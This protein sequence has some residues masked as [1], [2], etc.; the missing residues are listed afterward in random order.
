MFGTNKVEICNSKFIDISIYHKKITDNKET[1][2]TLP[3]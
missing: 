1:K 2:H 3:N